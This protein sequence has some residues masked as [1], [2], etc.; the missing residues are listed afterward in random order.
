M[1]KK[2]RYTFMDNLLFYCSYFYY[3]LILP[4]EVKKPRFKLWLYEWHYSLAKF[5]NYQMNVP[6][7]YTIDTIQTRFGT[8]KIRTNTSDAANVS[9]A[10][11]RRD[12]NYLVRTINELV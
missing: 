6:W 12:Q 7:K 8:F 9:P 4:L 3:K 10:F 2:Y 1:L 5:I 11:E